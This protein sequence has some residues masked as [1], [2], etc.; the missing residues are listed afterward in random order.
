AGSGFY[1]STLTVE[2]C[3]GVVDH[4]IGFK[5]YPNPASSQLSIE[6]KDPSAF[7]T[8]VLYDALGRTSRTYSLENQE[9]MTLDIATLPAGMYIVR[10][11]GEHHALTESL[12]IER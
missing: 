2:G 6:T 4:G 5:M 1:T 8:L 10:L 11:V 3:A 7:H 12:W 9:K